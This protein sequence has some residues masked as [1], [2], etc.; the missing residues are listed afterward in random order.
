MTMFSA[1]AALRP[2]DRRAARRCP[3]AC[4]RHPAPD[5]RA[6]GVA[7]QPHRRPRPRRVRPGHRRRRP[8]GRRPGRGA[9]VDAAA[10]RSRSTT[11]GWSSIELADGAGRRRLPLGR[12]GDADR[13]LLG[14]GRPPRTSSPTPTRLRPDP[15]VV[16][17]AARAARRRADRARHHVLSGGRRRLP[18]H[19]RARRRGQRGHRRRGPHAPTRSTPSRSRSSSSPSPR[20]PASVPRPCRTSTSTSGRSPARSSDV[21]QEATVI[22]TPWRSAASTPA[23]ASTAASSAGAPPATSR[24]LPRRG[25]PDARLPH[26]PGPP[27]PPTPLQPALQGRRR[28]AG[29]A[30]STPG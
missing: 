30:P 1:S 25:R 8:T 13:I 28:R 26:L 14:R 3:R 11:A 9:A 19:R 27:A 21:G 12:V 4:R 15:V 24:R 17:D 23:C 5:Q 22:S 6:G 20:P 29:A 2:A 10:S 7:L 16:A 18:P